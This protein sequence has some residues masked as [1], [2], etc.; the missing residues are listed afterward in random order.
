MRDARRQAI[1]TG[2]HV[3]LF[4]TE[5]TFAAVNGIHSA[6]TAIASFLCFTALTRVIGSTLVNV[7]GEDAREILLEFFCLCKVKL[8][9]LAVDSFPFGGEQLRNLTRSQIRVIGG[10]LWPAFAGKDHECVHGTFRGTIGIN[11][12]KR[13][14]RGVD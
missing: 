6:L 5:T 7:G 12:W 2:T 8:L 14:A 10:N 11:D 4:F 1:G 9:R 13:L 3:T